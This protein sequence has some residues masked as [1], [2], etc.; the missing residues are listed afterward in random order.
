MQGTD[1]RSSR[2][3][4]NHRRIQNRGNRTLFRC[5]ANT[6]SQD[7]AIAPANFQATRTGT[8][9]LASPPHRQNP[10]NSFRNLAPHINSCCFV[11]SARLP[12]AIGIP[13]QKH[14]LPDCTVLPQPSRLQRACMQ[15]K[16]RQLQ[17][18][19]CAAHFLQ[20]PYAFPPFLRCFLYLHYRNYRQWC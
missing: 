15:Q 17:N 14:M 19:V 4:A 3:P 2:R 7:W 1:H 9:S 8:E 20:R 13:F 6:S 11:H 10:I 5:S 12:S 18:R 16:C